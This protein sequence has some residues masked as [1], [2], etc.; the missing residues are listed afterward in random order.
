M[1]LYPLLPVDIAI[2]QPSLPDNTTLIDVLE[3]DFNATV[4][5]DELDSLEYIV[6]PFNSTPV[7]NTI[8]EDLVSNSTEYDIIN[9]L[10]NNLID[11]VD[12]GEDRNETLV[13]DRSVKKVEVRIFPL[14]SFQRFPSA[15]ATDRQQRRRADN[16]A[17]DKRNVR[18]DG[19]ENVQM[20]QVSN[21]SRAN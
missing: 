5:V 1:L 20:R 19:S 13:N 2:E 17:N 15:V 9:Q 11:I 7:N 8:D 16:A 3:G 14:I 4:V 21:R 6:D 12:D 18:L 10:E